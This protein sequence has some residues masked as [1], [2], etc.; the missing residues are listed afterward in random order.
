MKKT[1]RIF[2]A[3]A[4]LIALA[5]FAMLS[6]DAF[7]TDGYFSNGYGTKNKGFA[8]AGIAYLHGPFSAAINPAG[9]SFMQKK[10]SFD[11]SVGLFNPN[12][13]YSIIGAPTPPSQWGYMGPNGFVA[14]QRFMAFGLTEG[15][16]ESGS[17]T[18]IIPA[19]AFA[20]QLDE[21]NTIGLNFFGNG[22]MNTDYD[23]KTFYSAIIDGFGNP[24]PDGSPN[25]MA[26]VSQPTGVNITQMFLTL[27]YARKFGENHSFG[28]SPVLAYQTFEAKGL[29]AFRD[30]GMAGNAQLTQM[31]GWPNRSDY[32]TNNGVSSSTGI[33]F[34]LG[35][36]GELFEGFRLGASYQ[37]QIKMSKFD[38]YKGLFAEEGQFD[39]PANWT[40]GISYELCENITLMFD[41]KQIMYSGVKAVSN[42]MVPA[43]MQPMV[44]NMGPSFDP[45]NPATYFIPNE[46]FIALGDDNAAG[47]GW[48]DMM[49]FKLGAEFRQID[50]WAFRLGYSYGKQPIQES[51]V[52]FNILAPA[53][54]ESH[55]SLGF[56]KDIG[57]HALNFA[58]THALENSITGTNPF[59]PAQQIEL[60]M[61]Q[62]EFEVGFTF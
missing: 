45:T 50:T 25:P 61:N 16:V 15:T 42:P 34:R 13:Q 26:N 20:Y 51:E 43:T 44:P 6:T 31:L 27:T 8:G 56:T 30:M 2:K 10:W 52:M 58:V 3:K 41:V 57:N 46:N 22:G 28:I 19:I 39:I 47:F 59:D 48:E 40:A 62:W 54:N 11:V 32:V 17:K 7:A 4:M 5:I 18:F 53:V 12:R 29:E 9:I 23:M 60:K 37:P 55:V 33:G 14:D 49:I 35:Y 36:Q 1:Q 38:D 21:K 24:M